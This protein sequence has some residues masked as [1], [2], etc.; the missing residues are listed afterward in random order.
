MLEKWVGER[1]QRFFGTLWVK[2]QADEDSVT[3]HMQWGDKKTS[4][5]LKTGEQEERA[6]GFEF[7]DREVMIESET[8]IDENVEKRLEELGYR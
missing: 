8:G 2:Y 6:V 1:D 7:E 3:K 5:N 4:I